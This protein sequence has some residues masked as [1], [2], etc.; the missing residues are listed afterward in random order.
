M[1]L[2]CGHSST[3]NPFH[4]R[5]LFRYQWS[6]RRPRRQRLPRRPRQGR[7]PPKRCRLRRGAAGEARNYWIAVAAVAVASEACQTPLQVASEISCVWFELNTSMDSKRNTVS[8]GGLD[9][10][11][12]LTIPLQVVWFMK[13]YYVTR[14]RYW[15]HWLDWGFTSQ[16]TE[17]TGWPVMWPVK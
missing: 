3:L 11:T 7:R 5:L 13:E 16:L 2:A 9:S 15:Q 10:K 14:V 1:I 8:K 17:L 4:F 6:W 12:A